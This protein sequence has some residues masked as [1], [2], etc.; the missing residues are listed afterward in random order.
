[1]ASRKIR[2]G[3]FITF[4]GPEGCGKS[5][6]AKALAAF[7]RKRRFPVVLTRDPGGSPI[8]EEIRGLLLNHHYKGLSSLSEMLLYETCRASLVKEVILPAL[9]KGKIVI[10]DRFSDA[11]RVYQG[12]AG[13]VPEALIQKID[14]MARCGL[15]PDVTF[16]LDV[17]SREGLRR[18]REQHKSLDRMEGKPLRFHQ[19]VRRGYR[20]IAE[21][22]PQ[23]IRFIP[24]LALEKVTSQIFKEM[25]GVL[26]RHFGATF[27]GR[28]A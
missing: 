14:S 20:K 8:A 10:C 18:R 19:A 26:Q 21:E 3:L 24:P 4:D 11:T 9:Q 12:I 15:E 13:R 16:I 7:L 5:T 25:E 1:M 6:Q 27:R 2:K 22:S 28:T 17:E 23:R